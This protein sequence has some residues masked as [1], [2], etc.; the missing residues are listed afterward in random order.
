MNIQTEQKLVKLT[1][2]TEGL[3]KGTAEGME[4]KVKTLTYS[5]VAPLLVGAVLNCYVLYDEENDEFYLEQ[6]PSK[7]IVTENDWKQQE[8]D[9]KPK[10]VQVVDLTEEKYYRSNFYAGG[11][12]IDTVF[13]LNFSDT[14]I[15]LS[16]EQIEKIVSDYHKET[17]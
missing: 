17:I 6:I 11:G 8:A 10:E 1:E 15:V 4:W 7:R 9:Y 3:C 2:V 14:R 13:Q 5:K 12:R 16:A